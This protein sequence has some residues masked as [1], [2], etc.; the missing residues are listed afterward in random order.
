MVD[1][2][3]FRGAPAAQAPAQQTSGVRAPRMRCMMTPTTGD[4]VGVIMQSLATANLVS[5]N[6][7]QS[8]RFN[9]TFALYADPA[10]GLAFWAAQTS[11]LMVDFQASL[12]GDSWVSLMVGEVDRIEIEP[13]TGVVQVNGRDLS[14][15]FIETKTQEALVNQTSSQI[16]ATLAARHDMTADATPTTTL[17]GTYWQQDHVQISAGQF[18]HV[19]TEWDLLTDL[20]QREGFDLYVTGKVLHFHPATPPDAPPYV[21]TWVPPTQ[22]PGASYGRASNVCGLRMERALTLAKDVHVLVKSWN[23]ATGRAFTKTARAIGAKSSA[24]LK[25]SN[26]A[27][28]ASQRYVFTIPNLTEAE[29]QRVAN[30]KLANISQHERLISFSLPG[31]VTLTPRKMLRLDGTKCDFDQVYYIDNI[32]RTWSF[33][34]GFKMDVHAKNVDA[35]SQAL[36]K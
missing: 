1:F 21:V 35:R 4:G 32:T 10:F 34:Q 5:N 6:W 23:S 33:Q 26:Q 11:P 25:A 31:D 22:V 8:D 2:P 27:G 20:A 13:E 30:A 19:V 17:A 14:A 15:R 12:Q 28:T 24:A 16:V 9:A 29:A 36:L 18:S 3:E 7:Y